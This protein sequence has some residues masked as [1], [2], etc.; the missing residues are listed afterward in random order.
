M[1]VALDGA[2][3]GRR[4]RRPA[5]IDARAAWRRGG[6]SKWNETRKAR[7]RAPAQTAPPRPARAAARPWRWTPAASN[8]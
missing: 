8:T 3:A 4:T 1:T 6:D 2:A 7:P 5:R